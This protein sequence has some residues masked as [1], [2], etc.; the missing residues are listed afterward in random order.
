MKKVILV[1]NNSYVRVRCIKLRI[2][3]QLASPL[4]G[5]ESPRLLAGHSPTTVLEV[6]SSPGPHRPSE[7]EAGWIRYRL[8]WI[9]YVLL[10]STYLL[11]VPVV[12]FTAKKA[13]DA[14]FNVSMFFTAESLNSK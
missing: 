3:T 7:H 10:F 5:S 14:K 13:P 2:V 8:L 9:P 4:T 12:F 1:F 11:T 6:Y